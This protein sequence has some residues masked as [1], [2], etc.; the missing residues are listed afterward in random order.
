MNKAGVFAAKARGYMQGAQKLEKTGDFL[1]AREYYLKAAEAFLAAYRVSN[2]LSQKAVWKSYAVFLIRRANSL[3]ASPHHEASRQREDEF[4]RAEVEQ[5]IL[6]DRPNVR[7]DDVVGLDEAKE[8]IKES[9]VY[10]FTHPEM[11]R[12]YNVKPPKGVLLYGPPG[13]GKT[14]IAKAAATES[15]AA[16]ISANISDIMDK[17]VGESEK[18][19]REIFNLARRKGRTI[20]FLDEI[21]AVATSRSRTREGYERRL[22][23]EILNQLDGLHTQNDRLFV[24]GATNRPWDI[25]FALLRA[26]RFSTSIFI[27]HPEIREREM[28]F[29]LYLQTRPTAG[30]NYEELARRTPGFEASRIAE[31]CDEAGLIVIR[32]HISR[33]GGGRRRGITMNDLYRAIEIKKRDLI[34]PSWYAQSLRELHER[35]QLD[36]FPELVKAAQKVLSLTKGGRHEVL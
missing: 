24:L 3:K 16:F 1:A 30:I 15:N 22:V 13:C 18:K 6:S 17:F 28:L 25:D 36:Q 8:R 34:L 23:S 7:F 26:G 4:R 27:S 12:H 5:L 9:I 14:Y 33:D 32:E 31:V 29:K 11:Y 10:P 21:D 20:I 35:G 19:I 2:D